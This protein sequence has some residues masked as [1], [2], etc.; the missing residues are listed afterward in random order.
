M[1]AGAPPAK[2]H[3][4]VISLTRVRRSMLAMENWWAEID[5][6]VLRCLAGGSSAPSDIGHRLGMSEAA[7]VSVLTMLASEG[8]VQIRRATLPDASGDAP[9]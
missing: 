5:D 7:A 8:R 4:V 6:D 2:C 3:H 9:A 1:L